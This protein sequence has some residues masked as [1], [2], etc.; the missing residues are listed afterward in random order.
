MVIADN[1]VLITQIQIWV[2]LLP[3]FGYKSLVT[4]Y[5][6][7]LLNKL[8]PWLHRRMS[9]VHILKYDIW[10]LCCATAARCL[11]KSWM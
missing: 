8:V 11:V 2:W 4:Y 1:C 3:G 10:L 7:C 6:C 5:A 9:H